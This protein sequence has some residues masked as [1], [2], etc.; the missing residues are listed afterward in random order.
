MKYELEFKNLTTEPEDLMLEDYESEMVLYSHDIVND[1]DVIIVSSHNS[2]KELAEVISHGDL[3]IKKAANPMFSDALEI[4]KHGKLLGTTVKHEHWDW[5][6]IDDEIDWRFIEGFNRENERIFSYV[7]KI[8][9]APGA[10]GF[11]TTDTPEVYKGELLGYKFII[12]N[13]PEYEKATEYIEQFFKNHIN[14]I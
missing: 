13:K 14:R 2:L 12:P 7:I 3:V 6:Y 11:V 4:Y 1:H 9:S 8:I 10:W 5:N